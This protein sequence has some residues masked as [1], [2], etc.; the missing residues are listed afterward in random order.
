MAKGEK[1]LF[2]GEHFVSRPFPCVPPLHPP[3]SPLLLSL[4]FLGVSCHGK[5]KNTQSSFGEKIAIL[6]KKTTDW[7]LLFVVSPKTKSFGRF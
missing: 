4:V 1:H 5:S 3:P 2:F 7:L 6:C